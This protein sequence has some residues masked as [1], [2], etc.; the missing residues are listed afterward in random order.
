[1]ADRKAENL[2]QDYADAGFGNRLGFGQSPALLV[3]DFVMAY[4]DPAAPLYAGVEAELEV[5]IS[6]RQRCV[7]AG[8]PV[9]FTRV[10]YQPGGAD[11][12]YFFKKV[13]ALKALE[14][15]SPYAAFHKNLSPNEGDTV[16]TK[17]Y[18]SAF[19][20]T[21]LAST[22]RALGCDS[23]IIVG[24]TTS[25]CVRATALDALQNGF[26]PLVVSD[27]CG[28]RDIRVQQAN[29]FD[30]GAKYADIVTSEE[31]EAWLEANR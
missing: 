26:I 23:T 12:G 7:Q 6:L 31:V 1:M 14:R 27:A 15:G 22:L 4:L 18:A 30:L 17:Q 28:D 3:V 21:S 16:V 9:I 20:G 5:A 13:T 24:L 11:G 2:E 8:L 19:F 25:G 10:E 29:L